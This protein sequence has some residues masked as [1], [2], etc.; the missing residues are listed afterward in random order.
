MHINE[1][2]L[3]AEFLE[4]V[5]IDSFAGQERE[6]ADSL[7][8]KLI[9]LKAEVVEDDAGKT[10]QGNAGNLIA[11]IQGNA[12][13]PALLFA[14][15]MDRVSP[16]FG[17]KPIVENG[18]I[19][20]D[21]TTILAA[22]DVAGITVIL[23]GIRTA[24]EQL[25]PHGD[26]EIVFTIAEEGGLFGS[27]ALDCSQLTAKCAYFLDSDGPVGTIINQAPAHKNLD[28]IFHGR[29]SHAGV[30]PEK[31][32]N[33]IQ[34][35]AEAISNMNIG[36]IDNETTTNVGI[37]NGGTAVNIVPDLCELNCEVRS[38]DSVKLETQINQMTQAAENSATKYNTE[39]DIKI[40][41]CYSAFSIP[42]SAEVVSLAEKAARSI[43]VTPIIQMT[44]GGSDASIINKKG[45]PSVV[46]GLNY[47]DVHT[48]AESI[49]VADLVKA[50]EYVAAIIAQ[51]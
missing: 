25:I 19:R 50:A 13:K 47:Q 51:A 14:A 42:E 45:I 28:L 7:T 37:I 11:K 15:H 21:G 38:L 2:R 10:I 12:C 35:A 48:K 16:G 44:G 8:K 29:A 32:I 9:E 26:L 22:D 23:E 5:Q 31:G 17:I 24:K 39:I 40:T 34:A 36:R 18:I 3:L 43:G 41:D 1:K 46:L 20:S 27:K 33:A 6:M 49:A 4:L 30:K